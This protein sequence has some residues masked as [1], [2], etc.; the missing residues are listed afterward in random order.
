M[1][2]GW[3]EVSDA[4]I[5][6][7]FARLRALAHDGTPAMRAISQIL[8][9]G[10]EHNFA[11]ESGPQGPWPALKNPAPRRKGGKILQDTGRLAASVTPFHSANEA[12]IGSNAAY[13]AVHQLGGSI[14]RAAFSMRV[15]HRTN[16]KGEL[17]RT[18]RFN[19]RGL[20]FAKDSHKRAQARWFEVGAHKIDIPARPFM[21][22]FP[23]GRLQPR[24]LEAIL[25][26]MR[27]FFEPA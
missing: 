5:V 15:R 17:L 23:D 2:A 11:T 20:V 13:A 7:S 18:E 8:L 24:T 6:A 22:V 10:A 1:N 3:V 9:D 27:G 14:E 19:G 21:P 12:G 25:A 16:A 26:S 4:E